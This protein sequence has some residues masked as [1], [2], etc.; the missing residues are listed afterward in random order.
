MVLSK[1]ASPLKV[2]V[3]RRRQAELRK[4]VGPLA[5]SNLGLPD[6]WQS[7]DFLPPARLP[8]CPPD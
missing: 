3:C 2:S 5:G 1:R 6:H 4:L 8:A 7:G